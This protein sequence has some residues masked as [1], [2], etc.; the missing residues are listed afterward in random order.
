[1]SAL[2]C[3]MI[4]TAGIL[5]HTGEYASQ[6]K[7]NPARSQAVS[8]PA[9]NSNYGCTKLMLPCVGQRSGGLQ[10]AINWKAEAFRYVGRTVALSTIRIAGIRRM[11]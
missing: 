6:N 8:Y 3:V 10:A 5:A 1:V 9:S 4:R 2:M 7:S 11:G